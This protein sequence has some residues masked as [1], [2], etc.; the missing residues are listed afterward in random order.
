MRYSW[1]VAI[2]WTACLAGEL[3]WNLKQQNDK[4]LQIARASAEVAFEN[5]VVFR[6]WAARQG[7]V[8]VP[9]SPQ[10]PPNPYLKVP[11]REVTTTAGQTLTLIN[12][13]YMARLANEMSDGARGS[14]GHITS[15]KPLRP[16]NKP[17]A[18]E[19][20]A[21]NALEAGAPEAVSTEWINGQE[22]VRFMRPFI[23]EKPCLRCHAAQGYKEG[24]I[25]GGISVSVPT[26]PLRE[27]HRPAMTGTVLAHAALWIVGIAGIVVSARRLK[28]REEQIRSLAR[29]PEENPNP[30]VRVSPDGSVLYR[31]PAAA[32]NPSWQSGTDHLLPAPLLQLVSQA[33]EESRVI[34]RD[35]DLNGRYYAVAAAPMRAEGYANLYGRDVT[36]RKRAE[37]ALKSALARAEEGDRML[38]ALMEHVP[39]GITIADS[40]GNL[41]MVSRRGQELLGVAHAGKSID[42]VVAQCAVFQPD[43]QTPME[44][45]Q[46]PL[47]QAIQKGEVILDAEL[48]QISARGERL[49]LL[50]NAAPIQNSTGE[51]VGGIVVWRDITERRRAEDRVL[52][53]LERFELLTAT[54]SELLQS[55][56][57]QAVVESLCEK[58][59][60]H[61]DCDVFFNFLVD[62][63]AC[64]LRLNAYAGIPPEEA[65]KI[66]WL[67]FGVA[68]CGCAAR[69]GCRM[70]AENIPGNPDPRTEM[71]KSYGVKAYACHPLLGPGGEVIGTLSFGTRSRETFREEDLP[72]MKAVSDQVAVAMIRIEAEQSLRQ[73][74]AELERSNKELEQFAYVSAHDL[75]EPLRQVRSFVGLLK[76]RHGDKLEGKAAQYLDCIHDGSAR[77]S[78]LV[79]GL[80]A[81]SRVRPAESS[82]TPVSCA[83]A[84]NEA[85]QNLSSAIRESGA[86][87][88]RDD[89]PDVVA[90]PIQLMQ[91]FQ[92][93]ICNALTYRREGV[94]LEVHIG[95]RIDGTSRI[96]YVRDNGIGIAPEHHGKVFQIFSRL[97]GRS[98]YPGTG[99]GLAICKRIVEQHGGKIW[100]ESTPG[101]GST[102]CV[103]L[104]DDSFR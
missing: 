17:D 27:I 104:P 53:S 92:N 88:T 68:L 96:L 33:F 85:L 83:Q 18:W 87:I 101:E 58:V 65:D 47:S 97:H 98:T 36:E 48:V 41:R 11:N 30:V 52:R 93:L 14:R 84:V 35:L 34:E 94:P 66:R 2:V 67:D 55:T 56:E 80:L 71:V 6:K 99:I 57:P 38:S 51:I 3:Q 4:V 19:L 73:T 79:A 95:C 31:N 9:I 64:R 29:F 61:L 91:L 86:A 62:E 40:S 49:P 37:N 23:T 63:R 100:I 75:Q 102:F 42:E 50:C 81:Y 15:L 10:T 21:L 46:L 20:K 22:H 60:K 24:D 16:E 69:D 28:S 76:E 5:D 54:A 45:E 103:R 26:A 39:E 89:L 74:V 1:L 70:V 59:M 7:G 12:P 72:L 8:Y 13:A 32:S 44:R 77:M 78:E 25:R 90:D 43:G 82:R